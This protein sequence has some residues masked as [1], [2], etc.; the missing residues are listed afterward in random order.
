MASYKT[1]LDHTLVDLLTRSDHAAYNEIYNRYFYLIYTHAYK[2][3]RDEDQARDIVQDIFV[4]LWLKRE[5]LQI[6][7]NLAG[8]LYTAARNKVFDLFAHQEVASKYLDSLQQFIET[9]HAPTDERVRERELQA[10]IDKEIQ[11]LPPKMRQIFE[12]SRRA[13]MSYKEIAEELQVTE[14]NISKQINGA[15]RILRTKLGIL[16]GIVFLLQ[17]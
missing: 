12:M 13:G 15:L 1:L 3:L 14:N 6:S 8:Y 7:T 4:N 10:Q 2:K 17:K 16:A 9:Q 11:A 5:K